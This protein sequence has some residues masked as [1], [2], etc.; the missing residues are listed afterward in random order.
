M[1]KLH[2]VGVTT[3]RDGLILSVRRGARS[4]SY[5][6]VVDDDLAAAVEDHRRHQAE[7]ADEAVEEEGSSPR[8][9]STLSVREF[10]ARLRRGRSVA[11]VASAAGVDV[12]WVERFA[13]PVLAE[14]AR[15]VAAAR[16]LSLDRPRLGSSALPLGDAVQRHLVDR[17]VSMTPE[18]Q[19]ERWT[20]HLLDGGRWVVRFTYRY[21]GKERVLAYELDEQAG[22]ISALDR[23]S[24][25]MGY[26]TPAAPTAPRPGRG[27]EPARREP[28][29]AARERERATAAMR[30][31]A[32][33]Q[34]AEAERA[35]ARRAEDR[36]R[37][38]LDGAAGTPTTAS[39]ATKVAK[40]ARSSK[41]AGAS[42]GGRGGPARASK[43]TKVAKPVKS[44]KVAGASKGGRGGPAKASKATKVAK[45]AR[46]SKVAGASK[47]GRGGPA[48]ASKAT[49]VAK[50]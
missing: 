15:V 20:A 33:R 14:R 37:S 48:K 31:V 25:Q 17:G 6:L 12:A 22:S 26:V 43:A 21:R 46:S 18:E 50:P 27:A 44:S 19:A 3:D 11:D 49:K 9:E 39:K 24:G 8:P 32:T 35:V 30:D 10:Q 7:Q 1:Q 42:K 41:A 47:G 4:G 45:P 5:L 40:P 16:G 28:S 2:L 23:T 13:P 36:T 29:A 34:A 38:A